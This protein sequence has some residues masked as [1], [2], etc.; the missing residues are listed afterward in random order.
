M[1]M[2]FEKFKGL[3]TIQTHKRFKQ[4]YKFP[5]RFLNQVNR[6]EH[7][8]FGNNQRW[9]KPDGVFVCWF[10]QDAVFISGQAILVD[11]IC[12]NLIPNPL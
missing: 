4:S 8:L 9:C 7:L 6:F 11:E 12:V 3:G 10:G 5:H 1:F 2:M